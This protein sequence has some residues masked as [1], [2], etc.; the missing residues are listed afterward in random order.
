VAGS[1]GAWRVSHRSDGTT[2]S[3][4]TREAV[5]DG[6]E[7]MALARGWAAVITPGGRERARVAR[8]IPPQARAGERRS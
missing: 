2:T 5:L 4:R 3:T 7:V 8:I 1:R 6:D